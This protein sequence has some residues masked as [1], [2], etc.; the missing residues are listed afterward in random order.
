MLQMSTRGC[1]THKHNDFRLHLQ[2]GKRV[3]KMH[4][5]IKKCRPRGPRPAQISN[6]GVCMCTVCV[7]MYL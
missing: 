5:R 1:V 7:W 4:A 3:E 6:A 2:G